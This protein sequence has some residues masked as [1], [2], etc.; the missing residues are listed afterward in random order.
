[1]ILVLDEE[2]QGYRKEFSN[3]DDLKKK[4]EEHLDSN[5]EIITIKKRVVK[6][7]SLTAEAK[8]VS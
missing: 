3:V 7:N 2:V 8:C 1:M 5:V 6:D 4:V